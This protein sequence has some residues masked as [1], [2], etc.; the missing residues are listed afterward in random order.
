LRE[1]KKKEIADYKQ[2]KIMT[3]ELLANADLDI[4]GD[5]YSD[6]EDANAIMDQMIQEYGQKKRPP[7][8][9]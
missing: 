8:V 6:E 7:A 5:D 1:R 3:E 4:S 2:K 9:V